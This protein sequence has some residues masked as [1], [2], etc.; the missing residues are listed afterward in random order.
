MQATTIFKSFLL[1]TID[2]KLA[3]FECCQEY[4]IY[5]GNFFQFITIITTTE[6]ETYLKKI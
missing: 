1:S 6:D 3:V 5:Y 2:V 4:L